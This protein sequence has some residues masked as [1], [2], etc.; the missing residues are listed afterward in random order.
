LKQRAEGEE[1]WHPHL[2][3]QSR[4]PASAFS[5]RWA[6][7]ADNWRQLTAGQ[8]GIRTI[9]RFATAGLKTTIAGTVDF[10]PVEPF[11]S[12]ELGE[13]MADMAAEE[14]IAQSGIGSRGDFPGPLFLAVAPVEIEWPHR[15]AIAA[16]SGATTP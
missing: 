11:C 4:S 2:A 14:A 16:A 9:R 12:T 10:I 1:R 3:I 15:E 13:R 6:S 7:A 8:S 5:P